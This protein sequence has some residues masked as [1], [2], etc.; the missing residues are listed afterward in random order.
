M[1]DPLLEKACTPSLAM[2]PWHRETAIEA[3]VETNRRSRPILR[4]S[5][6][7]IGSTDATAMGPRE[8]GPG[9]TAIALAA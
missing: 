8:P 1:T 4:G 2:W 7:S 6:S 3:M 9:Y 5:R